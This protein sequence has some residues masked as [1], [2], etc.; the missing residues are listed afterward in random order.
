MKAIILG[1]NGPEIIKAEKPVPGE[2]DVLIKVHACGLNRADLVIVGGR[3]HGKVGGKGARLGLEWSGEV[4]SC[5]DKVEGLQPG[6][7]VMCNGGGGW[8]E[9]ALADWRRCHKFSLDDLTYE[10]AASLPTALQT[11]HDAIVTNGGLVKGQSILIQGASSGVGIMGLQ[12]A[13]HMGAGLIIGSSTN[14]ERRDQLSQFGADMAIDSKDP[15]WVE[16][17]LKATDG[18]GVDLIIDQVSANVMNQNMAATALK[19]CIVNV[20]RLGGNEG[21][22]DFNL[23]ALRRIRYVGVTFRTRTTDEISTIGKH[24]KQDLW[25]AVTSRQLQLPIA[26][27]FEL[28]DIHEALNCMER[29]QH[30]GKIILRVAS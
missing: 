15:G 13:R 10:Q 23:H 30:F 29:N 7:C 16:E 9:Y 5:G 21:E 17:V 4:I 24:M 19:G 6:D 26:E 8:A 14:K 20:G 11:M 25:G 28:A 2:N 27:V 3:S 1:D 22:F 18:R 12:I